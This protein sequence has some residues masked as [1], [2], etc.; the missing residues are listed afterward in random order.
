MK[1]K[2]DCKFVT[3][4]FSQGDCLLHSKGKDTEK[5]QGE[6][7]DCLKQNKDGKN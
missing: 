6:C 1:I 2:I 4:K 5:C 7:E 3:G